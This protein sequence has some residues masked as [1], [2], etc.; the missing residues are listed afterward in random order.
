MFLVDPNDVLLI[1]SLN[2]SFNEY[3]LN[4]MTFNAF[5]KVLKLDE[6]PDSNNTE[7]LVKKCLGIKVLISHICYDGNKTNKV[8]DETFKQNLINQLITTNSKT[9]NS[10]DSL[11]YD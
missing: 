2:N 1:P 6:T 3:L 7:E 10:E 5:A 8:M 9:N 4:E 11:K